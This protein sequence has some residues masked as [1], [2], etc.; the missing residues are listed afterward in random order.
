T[1]SN[2]TSVGIDYPL[3]EL[4]S[5]LATAAR[6]RYEP[7]PLG[8]LSAREALAAELSTAADAVSPKDLVLTA[9]TSEAYGFLFKL[10]GDPGDEIATHS[11]SYPLLDHLAALE[12]LQLRR[13]PLH[14]HGAR[15]ELDGSAVAS[16]LSDRTRAVTLI[17][18]NNPTG[19]FVDE[20]E[21][22]QIAAIL[23]PRRI[24]VISDEVFFDYPLRDDGVSRVSMA[25]GDLAS[26]ALGGL[27]KSAGLPHWKLG[28]IRLG[29]PAA[30]KM[31][32]RQ[33]LELIG[34]S[35]L[36]VA[37]PV[38]A[39]LPAILP[40]GRRIRASILARA[41]LNLAR[42]D[43]TIA[44]APSIGRLPA[45]GGWSAV[46]HVPLVESE[47]DLALALLE[48]YRVVVHPGY[49]F[50]FPTEGYLVVSLL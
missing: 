15:W 49:F 35:Y 42:I 8:L 5:C 6:A 41:R 21:R 1:G 29:G 28:W 25:A 7:D 27:S 50:D 13:F 14:F 45:E 20:R 33:G 3:E 31:A 23:E 37:T 40:L 9:S 19:S 18:P 4:E 30:W 36:S 38:Q 11:P 39:A 24:P 17:H 48:R 16:V 2:P 12:S 46:L 26:F 32:A 43:A 34:D 44:R 47:E 22:E 10:L